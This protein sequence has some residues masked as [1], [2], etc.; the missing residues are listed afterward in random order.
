MVSM[1]L[2]RGYPGSGK[3]TM[4][5]KNA[6]LTGGVLIE[7]DIIRFMLFGKYWGLK[8]KQEE[9]VTLT[10][11]AI[12]EG[13]LR[14]GSNVHIADTNLNLDTIKGLIKVGQKM[15][16]QIAIH[17][18]TTPVH[19]CI[20]RDMQRK[21]EGGRY[22]GGGAIRGMAERYPMPWPVVLDLQ[23]DEKTDMVKVVQL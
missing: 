5:R 7:R 19:E 12:I 3:S 2:Y 4:A 11:H 1:H 18:I 21:A 9:T 17:D 8:R 16:A 20:E 13:A 6:D 23:H 10:Q 14:H 22:V 15:G